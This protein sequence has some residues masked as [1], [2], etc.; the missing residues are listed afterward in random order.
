MSKFTKSKSIKF[1]SNN[2]SSI[3]RIAL[4]YNKEVIDLNKAKLSITANEEIINNNNDST[5]K[6]DAYS[7]GEIFP[8]KPKLASVNNPMN[9]TVNIETINYANKLDYLYKKQL[10]KK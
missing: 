3:N 7:L 5:V 4:Q 8:E 6:V 9:T 1:N 2:P 10:N